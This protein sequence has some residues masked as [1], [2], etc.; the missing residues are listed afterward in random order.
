MYKYIAVIFFVLLTFV[1]MASAQDV[2][3]DGDSLKVSDWL[4]R[5]QDY[6]HKRQLDLAE[7]SLR[8]A[9]R[10]ALQTNNL[11]KLES[12]YQLLDSVYLAQGDYEK[13]SQAC[14]HFMKLTDTLYNKYLE[15]TLGNIQHTKEYIENEK[16]LSESR[17]RHKIRVL[18]MHLIVVPFLV[19]IPFIIKIFRKNRYIKK[20]NAELNRKMEPVVAGIENASQ[21]QL[22]IQPTLEQLGEIFSETFVLYMPRD[23]VSGDFIWKK[24]DQRY[25]IVAVA[26]CT[27]HGMP[28]AMLSMFGVCTLNE[29]MASGERKANAILEQ[30]RDRI[31]FLMSTNTLN[32][33]QDGMDISLMVIDKQTKMLEF[34]GAYNSLCYIRNAEMRQMKATRCPI[35]EYVIE[36]PFRSETLQLMD[37]DC[38]YLM[39]DGYWSQFGGLDQCKMR[40]AQFFE[41]LVANHQKPML[42]QREIL[43]TYY[44]EWQGQNEQVDDVTV[45]GF[46]V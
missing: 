11:Q 7:I 45:V 33:M 44:R 32:K 31:K 9:V 43:E 13:A 14:S 40:Q 5:G 46:R 1:G 12:A 28:G 29:I 15:A 23:V 36:K 2:V 30:L 34:S 26:D 41:L 35:G 21:L 8:N 38:I 39:S 22:S 3:S 17:S 6:Y 25:D 20:L 27:G 16:A 18:I 37:G 24:S 42:E 4:S 10:E 19:A